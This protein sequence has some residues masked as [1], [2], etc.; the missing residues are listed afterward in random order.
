MESQGQGLPN[1]FNNRLTRSGQSQLQTMSSACI[2]EEFATN[3][4][5]HCSQCITDLF[6]GICTFDHIE[7]VL[8]ISLA[9][10]QTYTLTH[11]YERTSSTTNLHAVDLR[12]YSQ[13]TTSPT[14]FRTT[15]REILLSNLLPS[16][17]FE[18]SLNLHF[19]ND[20]A[21]HTHSDISTYIQVWVSVNDLSYSFSLSES[22]IRI[23]RCTRARNSGK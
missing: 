2:I 19:L 10:G 6:I 15:S 21:S 9:K 1:R 18:N 17:S 16:S 11:T 12:R 4:Q 22:A 8:S 13:N 7:T 14:S 5:L 3:I 20:I 23:W